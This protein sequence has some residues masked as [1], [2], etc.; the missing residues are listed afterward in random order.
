MTRRD[1]T[2]S[3]AILLNEMSESGEMPFID[4]V[5]RNEIVQKSLYDQGLSKCDGVVKV[6]AHQKGLAADIYLCHIGDGGNLIVDYS[7]NQEKAAKWHSR[8]VELGGKEMMD[9]DKGHYEMPQ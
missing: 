4:W 7:W 8:W 6:S 5:L 1:F 2:K 9:W 3:L